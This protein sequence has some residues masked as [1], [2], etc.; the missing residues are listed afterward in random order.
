MKTRSLKLSIYF[1]FLVILIIFSCRKFLEYQNQKPVFLSPL[2]DRKFIRLVPSPTV[3]PENNLEKIVTQTLADAG[4]IYGVDIKNFKTGESY[5]L[6]DHHIFWSASLYKLWVLG[7]AYEQIEEQTLHEDTVMSQ[8]IAVLNQKFN[9][10]EED[11]ERTEGEITLS[12]KDAIENMVTVSDNYA[13]LLLVGKLRLSN[14]K[15]FLQRNSLNEIS[16]GSLNNEPQATPYSISQLLEK[17]YN[18][19]L[20]NE[21]STGKMLSVLKRQQL[22]YALPKYLSPETSIAHKTGALYSFSHDAGIVYTPNGDYIIVVMTDTK[23]PQVAD[24]LIAQISKNVYEYF[25]QK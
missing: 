18:G 1:L 10:P 13:A 16:V 24:E 9:I 5:A 2:P 15:A 17:L 6:N 22:N 19:D 7:A 12:V 4:G 21:E 25:T 3:N 23:D 14:I 11:A 8:Q 20:G